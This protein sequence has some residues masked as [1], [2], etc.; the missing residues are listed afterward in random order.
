MDLMDGYRQAPDPDQTKHNTRIRPDKKT[1]LHSF[2]LNTSNTVKQNNNKIF[3]I[4]FFFSI[5][6]WFLFFLN[7]PA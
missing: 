1:P 4:F 2:S 3:D 7:D 6:I 5:R